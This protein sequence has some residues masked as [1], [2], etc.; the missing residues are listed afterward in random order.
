[1]KLRFESG[2]ILSSCSDQS[3]TQRNDSYLTMR[4]QIEVY[5]VGYLLYLASHLS[6]N[7]I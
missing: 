2:N 1:M 5:S 3:N 6:P 7:R 4:L